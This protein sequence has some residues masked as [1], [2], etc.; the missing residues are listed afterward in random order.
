MEARS[1][2]LPAG[3]RTKRPRM[4]DELV[5]LA[6]RLGADWRPGDN[7]MTWIRRHEGAT[8]E[9]S[10]LVRDGW[11]WTD[12][13]KALNLAG[14]RYQT[15]TAI[16][17]DVLRRK[18]SKA[19]T[20]EQKRQASE[21]RRRSATIGAMTEFVPPRSAANFGRLGQSSNPASGISAGHEAPSVAMEPEF[22]PAKLTGGNGAKLQLAAGI[23]NNMAQSPALEPIDVDAVIARLSGRNS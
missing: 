17:G 20:D 19:R 18:A 11:S 14:I 4:Q 16:S 8:A 22:K 21:L 10:Q 7:V 2:I 13:G 15:G 1:T 6:K 9:L 3:K 5:G 12:L 23:S